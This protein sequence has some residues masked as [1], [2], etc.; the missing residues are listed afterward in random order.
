M[1]KILNYDIKIGSLSLDQTMTADACQLVSLMTRHDLS[2]SGGHCYVE[3]LSTKGSLPKLDDK[4][5]IKLGFDGENTL[6]FTGKIDRVKA[7]I[8]GFNIYASDG[9]KDLMQHDIAKAYEKVT[10]SKIVKDLLGKAKL[11]V[12]TIDEGPKLPSYILHKGITALG[13]LRELA[14]LL[15]ADIYTDAQGKVHVKKVKSQSAKHKIDYK[16]DVLGLDVNQKSPIFNGVEAVGEG[17]ASSKGADRF[18]WLVKDSKGVIDNAKVSNGTV[19]KGKGSLSLQYINGAI[20][21]KQAATE[22]SQAHMQKIAEQDFYGHVNMLGNPDIGADEYFKLEQ[23]PSTHHL[24][25][26]LASYSAIR[27]N[28]VQHQIDFKQGFTTRLEF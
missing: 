5:T 22:I 2:A 10:V 23:V 6:V 21:S 1:V 8:Q 13:H 3:V 16:Q 11:S 19:S 9:V 7:T 25:K 4:V 28:A 14:N 24:Y 17:S 12:G 27:I 26:H 20:R 18:Y 15:G